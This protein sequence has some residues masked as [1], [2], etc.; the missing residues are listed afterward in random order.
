M[1]HQHL[2]N[3]MSHAHIGSYAQGVAVR[4]LN[5][6]GQSSKQPVEIP[7]LTP[8]LTLSRLIPSIPLAVAQYMDDGRNIANAFVPTTL[9]ASNGFTHGVHSWNIVVDEASITHG[10]TLGIAYSSN[11]MSRKC[12]FLCVCEYA[13][14]NYV[15]LF[16]CLYVCTYVMYVCMHV[17][18]SIFVFMYVC[19]YVYTCLSA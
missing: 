8:S 3:K 11:G 13:S 7:T 18:L 12:M 17:C 6:R 4:I 15:H 1:E 2:I 14:S 19:I 9:M 16:V 10:A 5:V